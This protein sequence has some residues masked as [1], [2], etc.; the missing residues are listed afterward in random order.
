MKRFDTVKIEKIMRMIFIGLSAMAVVYNLWAQSW[1]TFWSAVI[2]LI[3]FILPTIMANR[4]N[5]RI[6]PPF[7]IIIML[8][9]FASM[10]LGEIHSYFYRFRWWDSM[11]HTNSAIMLGYIGFL[12]IDALNNDSRMHIRLSPFFMALFSFCFA[13][14]IGTLWEIFEYSA[15]AL[16]GTNMQKARNLELVYGIFDTRLGVIDTMQDLMVD[17][18]GALFVSIVG[19]VHLKF[20]KPDDS[21]FWKL[22][23]QFISENPELFRK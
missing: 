18:I 17:A 15:D 10:Y 9:I 7:Q 2:T 22:H 8:F 21:T 20:R 13:I 3:L 11:L 19:F 1:E 4:S 6:P 16:L 5:I 14:M 23:Q 12:L